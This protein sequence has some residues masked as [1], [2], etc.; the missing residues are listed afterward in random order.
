[1]KNIIDWFYFVNLFH[2]EKNSSNIAQIYM[3]MKFILNILLL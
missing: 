1:M 3:N 2:Q